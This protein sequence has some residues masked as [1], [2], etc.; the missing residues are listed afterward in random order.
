MS[1][2][3]ILCVCSWYSVSVCIMNP[4]FITYQTTFIQNGSVQSVYFMSE[5]IILRLCEP[6]VLLLLCGLIPLCLC[7]WYTCV[8]HIWILICVYMFSLCCHRVGTKFLLDHDCVG[9]VWILLNC[10][11]VSYVISI[12]GQSTINHSLLFEGTKGKRP[13]HLLCDLCCTE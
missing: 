6:N 8:K 12:C 13:H 11:Y 2:Y 9:T 7:C 1:I 5:A 3:V 4:L 10:R